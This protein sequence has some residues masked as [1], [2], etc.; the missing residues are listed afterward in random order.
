MSILDKIFK[1]ITVEYDEEGFPVLKRRAA[2]ETDRA[3]S[4]AAEAEVSV[5][6]EEPAAEEEVSSEAGAAVPEEGTVS[7]EAAADLSEDVKEEPAVEAEPAAEESAEEEKEE[8]APVQKAAA[9]AEPAGTMMSAE[10]LHEKEEDPYDVSNLEPAEVFRFFREISAIPH[11]SF[12]TKEISDYLA[13]FAKDHGFRYVQD[14]AGNVV[15]YADAAPGF[16]K[17]PALVL[18][19]HMD[20]V[21]EKDPGVTLNMDTEPITLMRDGEWLTA[22]GTTLGGDDGIAVA[23]M[24]AVLDDP[25][26]VHPALECIFTV[27]EEVGML[28][29]EV[30]DGSL[31]KGRRMLNLDSEMDG[32][33]TAGCAGGTH[34]VLTLHCKRNERKG[35]VLDLKVSGLLGGHSGEMP[36]RG[37]ANANIIMGRVLYSLYQ[38]TPFRLIRVDGGTK[39]NAIPREACA[40]LLFTGDVDKKDMKKAVKALHDMIHAEYQVTDPGLAIS[41]EWQEVEPKE[42]KTAFI[43]RD[44][45][46]IIRFLMS[47]PDGLIEYMPGFDRMPQTSLNMGILKTAADGIEATF[48]VRS[49]LNSQREMMNDKLRCIAAQFD[50]RVDVKGSY[51]AWEYRQQSDFRDMLVS[52]YKESTGREP[53]VS[54]THGGLECG[55]LSDKLPGLDCVSIG[56]RMYGIHTPQEKLHIASTAATWAYLKA[57]LKACAEK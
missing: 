49:A 11:G 8:K 5:M 39:D 50:G 46:R 44:T 24:L 37:R 33:F 38:E 1:K 3:E 57:A 53:V 52:L 6:P 55:L 2:D 36:G 51:P 40:S 54:V 10:K 30:L 43:K 7:D 19:G 21:C 45:R 56:P 31:I 32:I 41:C 15:I 20:M 26:M 29:A 12:H 18:Q 25:S 9:E 23:Y 47:V 48:L 22:D 35:Q 17:A 34:Q 13:G 42:P 28:G 14:Q 27:D 4:A 16:E